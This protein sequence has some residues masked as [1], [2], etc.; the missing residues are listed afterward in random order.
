MTPRNRRHRLR[1]EPHEGHHLIFQGDEPV[2][3]ARKNLLLLPSKACAQLTLE[4]LEQGSEGSFFEMGSFYA[5]LYKEK[6]KPSLP[7]SRILA[8]DP[9]FEYFGVH[10]LD[11]LQENLSLVTDIFQLENL[12]LAGVEQINQ[13][14]LEFSKNLVRQL[15]AIGRTFLYYFHHAEGSFLLGALYLRDQLDRDLLAEYSVILRAH[16][17]LSLPPNQSNVSILKADWLQEHEHLFL[18]LDSL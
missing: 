1:L 9:L 7:I 8:Q 4:E 13:K 11:S 12:E 18:W 15:K 2:L 10:S 5:D 17:D 14:H 6:K 3:T 16:K